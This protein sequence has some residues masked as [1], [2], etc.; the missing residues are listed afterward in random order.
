MPQT[1]TGYTSKLEMFE[2]SLLA[3][4]THGEA[5]ENANNNNDCNKNNK[6]NVYRS[7]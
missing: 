7:F 1:I 3:L 6:R 4:K 5:T 2:K